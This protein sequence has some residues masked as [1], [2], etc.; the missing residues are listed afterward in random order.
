MLRTKS[1]VVAVVAVVGLVAAVTSAPRIDVSASGATVFPGP[2]YPSALCTP[3]V[4]VSAGVWLPIG[5]AH[6]QWNAAAGM[7]TNVSTGAAPQRIVIGQLGEIPN[8]IAVNALMR[9]CGLPEIEYSSVTW[10]SPGWSGW[11]TAPTVLGAEATLDFSV[12][13]GAVPPNA[14]IRLANVSPEDGF[15]GMLLNAALN[16]GLLV[17]GT[18]T[19]DG[20]V[21]RLSK[22]GDFPTGGCIISISYGGKETNVI[23]GG[24]LTTQGQL[25]GEL[26]DQMSALNVVTFVS[27][28]DEGSG[29]C[30]I[31]ASGKLL[32]NATVNWSPGTPPLASGFTDIWTASATITLNGHGFTDGQPVVLSRVT[33]PPVGRVYRNTLNGIYYVTAATVDT[34]AIQV[35]LMSAADTGTLPTAISGAVY[36]YGGDFGISFD[37]KFAAAGFLV[38]GGQLMPQFLSTNPNVVA[39]GGTQWIPQSV[40]LADPFPPYV[41][42]AQYGQFVWKDSADNANCANAL[43]PTTNGQQGGTGGQSLIFV[44]PQYQR[45]QARASY[46]EAPLRRM[47][48]DVSGLAGW[49]EYALGAPLRTNVN[50]C[51]AGIA[52]APP[53]ASSRDFPWQ[54]VV[55]TSAATP[56]T[57]VGIANVNAILSARGFAPIN[58][59]GGAMDIHN[60]IYDRSFAAAIVD[61]P[62]SQ[63]IPGSG[64]FPSGDNDIFGF[65]CCTAADGYD[66]ATGMGVVNFTRLANLLVARNTPTPPGPAPAPPAPAPTAPAQPEPVAPAP[67]PNP[68]DQ[69]VANP[70]TVTASVLAAL[71]PAQVAQIPPQ[72]FGQLP[73]AAFRGLTGPQARA[74]SPGQVAA[75][76]PARARAIRP[77]VLRALTPAQVRVMRPAAVRALRPNQI[78]LLRPVQLAGLSNK[79]VSRMRPVQAKELS[80]AQIRA[81]TPRQ[82]VIINRKR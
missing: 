15:Y 72:T 77:A 43:S 55:G 23:S 26:L 60:I 6:Q 10:P 81:L 13:A 68:V 27:T 11:G 5:L 22:G 70:S 73:A 24:S 28:G 49:P 38:E 48:P 57:A 69:I 19:P 42:G 78:R 45:A 32:T 71:T 30:I 59:A 51:V 29:G 56:L 44:M 50:F 52:P 46:P 20:P 54:P 67:A 58:K 14:E 8:M 2:A 47:V 41:P 18:P 39:V 31:G 16:C 61:V 79:Q 7:P 17:D 64:T 80:P 76:R 63:T 75:I 36:T 25:T 9:Q 3:E 82:Q 62:A 1:A 37:A 33:T 12:V 53:C 65:G 4:E 74:L 66:M 21:P 40:S 35:P 34:F